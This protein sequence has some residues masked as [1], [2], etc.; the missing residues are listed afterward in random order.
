MA[1][2]VKSHLANAGPIPESGRC[3][4]K[5]NDYP[6]QYSGLESP[7]DRGAWQAT[8]CRVA[9]SWTQLKQL[10]MHV[11]KLISIENIQN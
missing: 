6:L 9:K 1:L 3:P 10:S 7:M 5:E 8:T 11:C 4:G 2:V